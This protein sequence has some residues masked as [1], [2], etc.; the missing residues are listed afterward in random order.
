MCTG[1]ILWRDEAGLEQKVVG[2]SDDCRSVVPLERQ[3]IFVAGDD[4]IRMG[5]LGAF[6]DHVVGGIAA[7]VEGAVEG[8]ADGIFEHAA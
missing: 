2:G 3:K 8:D 6:E 5:A 1:W 7:D 4:E